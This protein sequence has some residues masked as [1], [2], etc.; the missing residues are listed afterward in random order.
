MRVE[1]RQNKGASE[2][3]GSYF[4]PS[5]CAVYKNSIE[6]NPLWN[7]DSRNENTK[8]ESEKERES[9]RKIVANRVQQQ[10]IQQQQKSE[11]S[12]GK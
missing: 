11:T 5:I 3:T 4:F 8:V 1:M 6:T 9:E 7:K 2:I 10:Q 12:L